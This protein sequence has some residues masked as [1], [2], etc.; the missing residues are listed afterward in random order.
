MAS[1]GQGVVSVWLWV[2]ILVLTAIPIV[3]LLSLVTLAFFV[4]NQNLQNYGK[5]SLI[6]IVI[7]ATFFWLLRYVSG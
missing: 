1:E 4:Q 3:N 5:A 2:L 6:V 7:P